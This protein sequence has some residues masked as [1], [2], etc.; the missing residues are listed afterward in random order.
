MDKVYLLSIVEKQK[1]ELEASKKKLADSRKITHAYIE[2]QDKV[3]DDLSDELE[4][5]DKLIVDLKSTEISDGMKW[6]CIGEIWLESVETCPKCEGDGVGW[7][8]D[9]LRCDGRGHLI[10]KETL[11]WTVMKDVYNLMQKSKVRLLT[12]N[13]EGE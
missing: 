12:N 5:K 3:I 7:A 1:E 8:S 6:E 10:M 2:T 9:C 11:D 4:A 13:K